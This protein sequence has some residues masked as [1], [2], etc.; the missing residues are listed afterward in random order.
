M[1]MKMNNKTKEEV[2]A[3]MQAYLDYYCENCEDCSPSKKNC[4]LN[5][6]INDECTF[7]GLTVICTE[8]GFNDK[9]ARG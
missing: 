9:I 6:L 1:N 7:H 3:G 8:G 4:M 2:L 5:K